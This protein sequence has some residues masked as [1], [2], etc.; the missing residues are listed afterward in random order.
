MQGA[1]GDALLDGLDDLVI[2]DAG[3]GELHTAMEH[4]VTHSINLVHGLDDAVL[5]VNQNVQNRGDGLRMG[6][7][8][9]VLGD[10][11]VA[12]LVG[13]TAVD[14]NTLAQT[15]C[16]HHTG[17]GIHQLILQ[18]GGT[19]IDNQNVHGNLPPNF[20]VSLLGTL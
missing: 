15:L 14:V 12:G 16:G 8:G 17:I 13:Q 20:F 9:D 1:Q 2:N 7:H 4:T 3:V 6:G 11:L 18:A 19:G 5:G 10:L